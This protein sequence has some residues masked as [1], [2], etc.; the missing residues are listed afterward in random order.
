MERNMT[1]RQN[2]QMFHPA[3]IIAPLGAVILAYVFYTGLFCSDDT[4]YL[5][6]IQKITRGEFIDLGSIAERRLIFLLPGA[7][8]YWLSGGGNDAAIA[9]YSLFYVATPVVAWWATRRYGTGC[10]FIAAIVTMMAPLLYVRA[11][12][13][14]PD[15]S[16]TFISALTM[17]LTM[18]ALREPFEGTAHRRK[19]YVFGMGATAMLGVAIKESNAVIAVLPFMFLSLSAFLERRLGSGFRDVVLAATGVVAVI[20]VEYILY[21]LFAGE[22]HSSLMN[23]AS[24]H[25]FLAYTKTQGFYPWER[26]IFLMG[27][28]D[29]WTTWMFGLALVSIPVLALAGLLGKAWVR[30]WDWIVPAVFFTWTLAYFTIGTSSFSSYVPPV[31]QERYYAPCVASAAVLVA[32]LLAG[33]RGRF[34]WMGIAGSVALL[35]F[36]ASGVHGSFQQRGVQYWARAKDAINL[37]L[38]DVG[39]AD[40]D[41]IVVAGDGAV[42]SEV[43]RC[44]RLILEDTH[45]GP[46][47]IMEDATTEAPFFILGTTK[48]QLLADRSPLGEKVRGN[49]EQGRW[50][51]GM[52]GYYFADQDAGLDLWWKPRQEA[53]MQEYRENRADFHDQ[54]VPKG[55]VPWMKREMH[56]ELYL[57]YPKD[58]RGWWNE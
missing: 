7:L 35:I 1:A 56:A 40:P 16:S 27:I 22:W 9:V 46:R 6:G 52:V 13:L 28:L 30:A 33:P 45:A 36:L 2:W 32:F 54:D 29:R 11:G 12:A 20:A 38:I 55:H 43:G 19:L 47:K 44:L 14:L 58:T 42:N 50:E 21:K 48:E 23:R 8:A 39:R 49:V 51:M 4:R 31:M 26:F 10:A 18:A 34:K 24:D 15:V 57:V 41:A 5:I 37:A 3:M 53:V 25:G 17:A